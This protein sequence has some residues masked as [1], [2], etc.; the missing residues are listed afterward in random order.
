MIDRESEPVT[1]QQTKHI[2]QVVGTLLYY[3]QVIDI[4]L[5][6]SLSS[7]AHRQNNPTQ[8]TL[9]LVE[10]L[11]NYCSTYPVTILTYTSRDMLL[12]IHSDVSYLSETG[13]KSRVGGHFYIGNHPPRSTNRNGAVHTIASIIKHVVASAA[14]AEYGAL[15]ENAKAAVPN[16]TELAEMGHP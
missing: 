12:K 16:R 15:F 13:S 11:L 9:Q 7:I 4:S 8:H 6:V 10:H 3:A 2:Q 14:E 1:L 5:L